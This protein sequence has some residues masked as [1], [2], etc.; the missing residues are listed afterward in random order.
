M[1]TSHPVDARYFGSRAAAQA[2]AGKSEKVVRLGSFASGSFGVSARRGRL[3]TVW[4]VT[5]R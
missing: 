2:A 5:A 4:M 1:I 3:V